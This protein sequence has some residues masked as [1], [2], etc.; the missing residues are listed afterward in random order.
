MSMYHLSRINDLIENCEYRIIARNYHHKKIFSKLSK[1]EKKNNQ[2]FIKMVHLMNNLYISFSHTEKESF[3]QTTLYKDYQSTIRKIAKN[4][5]EIEKVIFELEMTETERNTLFYDLALQDRGL[6]I[7]EQIK[8]IAEMQN[9]MGE[10]FSLETID[11]L[12]YILANIDVD[13]LEKLVFL[14]C[15][16]EKSRDLFTVLN[17]GMDEI[18]VSF[19]RLGIEMANIQNAINF[20]SNGEAKVSP[21]HEIIIKFNTILTP[22]FINWIEYKNNK[23]TNT[24]NILNIIEEDGKFKLN[25]DFKRTQQ[26]DT[27]QLS[28]II[29]KIMANWV[30]IPKNLNPIPPEYQQD[31]LKLISS[32][33]SKVSVV[34]H[35]KVAI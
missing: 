27:I 35:E 3:L 32:Y 8:F 4:I 17:I 5:P 12:K 31:F 11:Q 7:K 6:T 1:S 24:I 30:N 15:K 34:C 13:F 18:I 10:E 25:D 23:Q 29:D 33:N 20:D 14:N 19:L 2:L 22:F 9:L 21:N 16:E 26:Y 28:E